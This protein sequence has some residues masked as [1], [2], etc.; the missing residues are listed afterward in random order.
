MPEVPAT[1]SSAWN[2]LLR[3]SLTETIQPKVERWRS[4]LDALLVFVRIPP[5]H[6]D[7]MI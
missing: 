6:C 1:S 4:G 5:F 3:S 7:F 2:A